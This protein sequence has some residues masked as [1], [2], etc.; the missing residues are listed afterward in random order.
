[1]TQQQPITVKLRGGK[2]SVRLLGQRP[3]IKLTGKRPRVKIKGD[4]KNYYP[5]PKGSQP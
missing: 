3:R 4:W 1:M 5:R 2:T